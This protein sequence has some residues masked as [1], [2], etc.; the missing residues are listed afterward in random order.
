MPCH[1]SNRA[2]KTLSGKM[3][4]EVITVTVLL[5]FASTDLCYPTEV[6]FR[7][8]ATTPSASPPRTLCFDYGRRHHSTYGTFSQTA[9]GQLTATSIN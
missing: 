1:P 7:Q 4:V 2:V 6:I 5:C 8:H 3:K 9:D